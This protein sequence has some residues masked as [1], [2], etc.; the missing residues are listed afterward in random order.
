MKC[1]NC[2]GQNRNTDKTCGQCGRAINANGALTGGGTMPTLSVIAVF[3]SRVG[4]YQY[5]F[6]DKSFS[7]A[8]PFQGV[9]SLTQMALDLDSAAFGTVQKALLNQDEWVRVE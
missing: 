2:K 1:W 7:E 4:W 6:A 5:R 9:A 8:R 3:I